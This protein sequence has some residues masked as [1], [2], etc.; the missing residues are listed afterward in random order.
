MKQFQ[1]A[2]HGKEAF[3]AAVSAWQSQRASMP[4]FIH[5]FS[6]GANPADLAAACEILDEIMPDVEYAGASASG[7]IRTAP[8][9]SLISR[10]T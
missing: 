2:Y 7:C 8:G 5:L 9:L 4:A 6:D 3:R 1:T 10:R